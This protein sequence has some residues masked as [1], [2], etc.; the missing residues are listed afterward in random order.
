MCSDCRVLFPGFHTPC[1]TQ[2][3]GEQLIAAPKPSSPTATTTVIPPSLR[4]A[5]PLHCDLCSNVHQVTE[6]GQGGAATA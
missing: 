2:R 1:V 4:R 6:T 5:F 3:V